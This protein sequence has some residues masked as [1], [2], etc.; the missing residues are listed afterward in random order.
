MNKK[1]KR[2]QFGLKAFKWRE[3]AASLLVQKTRGQIRMIALGGE[4]SAR[5]LLSLIVGPCVFTVLQEL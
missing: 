1:W 4:H 3:T 5:R 2:Q